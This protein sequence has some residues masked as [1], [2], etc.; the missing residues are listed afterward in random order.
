LQKQ[1]R[2]SES[3]PLMGEFLAAWPRI[4]G[5]D[6]ESCA[7]V[8]GDLVKAVPKL[9]RL[10][11][12]EPAVRT[13]RDFQVRTLAAAAPAVLQS[14]LWLSEALGD[15]GRHDEAVQTFESVMQ[16]WTEGAPP[17]RAQAAYGAALVALGR[18]DEG[19][20]MLELAYEDETDAGRRQRTAARLA[21]VCHGAGDEDAAAE[22]RARATP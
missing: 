6:H 17:A 10:G 14:E 15:L 1:G 21:E 19:R 3:V 16:G 22:W 13:L 12:A 5:D 18:V 20:D 7:V 8:A 2:A 11:P 9:E 4:F